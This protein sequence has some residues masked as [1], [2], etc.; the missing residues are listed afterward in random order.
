MTENEK[1]VLD[2]LKMVETRQSIGELDSFDHPEIEQVEYANSITKI[3]TTRKLKDLK[4]GAERGKKVLTKEAYDVKSLV[5]FE[6]TVLL[7]CT[8]RGTLAIP[9]GNIP[10]GGQMVAH[11]AEVFEFKEGKIFR[12]RNYDCFEPFI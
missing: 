2:F 7:E 4:D 8:W 3:T 12:Q 9:I 11:F 1:L 5:S 6:N 10:A